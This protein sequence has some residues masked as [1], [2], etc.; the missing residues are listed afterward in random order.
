MVDGWMNGWI[1][2]CMALKMDG[3]MD[4]WINEIQKLM[5]G[6]KLKMDGSIDR[7]NSKID[8]GN[9]INEKWMNGCVIDV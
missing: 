8:R 6:W 5:N 1:D 3:R 4:G 9:G 2:R 7:W